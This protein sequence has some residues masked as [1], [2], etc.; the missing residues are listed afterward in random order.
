MIF[1][2]FHVQRGTKEV[3]DRLTDTSKYTGAHKERFDESGR[4]KGLAGRQNNADTSGYVT[5]YKEKD[6]YGRGDR[7][8]PVSQAK[9]SEEKSRV[10]HQ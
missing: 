4:G 6:T 10:L 1:I 7:E 5:G 2:C 9:K 8:E 3:T